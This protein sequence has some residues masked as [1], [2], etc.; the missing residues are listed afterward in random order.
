[1]EIFR[2]TIRSL[3]EKNGSN[4]YPNP[5]MSVFNAKIVTDFMILEQFS[6]DYEE[7][8]ITALNSPSPRNALSEIYTSKLASLSSI[9]INRLHWL[10]ETFHF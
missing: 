4:H 8:C 2:S 7:E 1:M 5:S 10:V 9:Y 3:A 6:R